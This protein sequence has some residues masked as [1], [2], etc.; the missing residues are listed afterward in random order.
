MEDNRIATKTCQNYPAQETFDS[1]LKSTLNVQRQNLK[2][3]QNWDYKCNCVCL[4]RNI[5]NKV[6]LGEN[7]TPVT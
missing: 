3:F 6:K 5:A 1:G 2:K 4:E 7:S